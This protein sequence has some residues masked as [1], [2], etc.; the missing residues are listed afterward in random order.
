MAKS[1]KIKSTT[2]LEGSG[3]NANG[4]YAQRLA[5]TQPTIDHRRRETQLETSLRAQA[6][7]TRWESSIA[8]DDVTRA[9][10]WVLVLLMTFI[11]I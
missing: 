4:F 10:N 11:K 1:S 7:D 6:I 5:S 2:R 8:N 9:P 3:L